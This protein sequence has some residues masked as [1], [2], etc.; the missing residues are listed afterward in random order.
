MG[1]CSLLCL[2]VCSYLLILFCYFWFIF[3]FTFILTLEHGNL[4]T[5]NFTLI[6]MILMENCLVKSTGH[7]HFGVHQPNHVFPRF[8]TFGSL[9]GLYILHL[10]LWLCWNLGPMWSP[11]K[12]PTGENV[13]WR[14]F[15]LAKMATQNIRTWSFLI[16]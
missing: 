7:Q 11:G 2:I 1:Y 3:V 13:Y 12:M 16:S 8:L 10:V 5:L 14:K 4:E 15:V 6:F 9:A